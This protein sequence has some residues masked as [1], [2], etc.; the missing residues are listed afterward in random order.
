[1][2]LPTTDFGGEARAFVAFSPRH[3]HPFRAADVDTIADEPGCGYWLVGQLLCVVHLRRFACRAACET[4][5]FLLL[6]REC[7]RPKIVWSPTTVVPS[8]APKRAHRT[9]TTRRH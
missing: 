6:V 9:T 2:R 5:L 7:F 4:E 8:A 3:P 1:M